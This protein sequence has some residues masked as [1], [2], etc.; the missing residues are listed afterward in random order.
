MKNLKLIYNPFSGDKSFKFDL[1]ICIRIFQSSGYNVSVFRTCE[2]G[3]IEKHIETMSDDYDV[4]VVS[5]GDGTVNIVLNALLKRSLSIPI[6]IIPSGTANDFAKFLGLSSDIEKNCK[7]IMESKPKKI[8]VGMVNEQ[9]FINVCGSGLLANV[10][11]HVDNDF[12]NT[13]GTLAYYI[14]AIEEIPKFSPMRLKIVNSM[15]I[16]EDNF[17]L[18]LVL[19][20]SGAGSFDKIAPSASITDGYFDFIGIKATPKYEIA[21]LFVKVLLGEHIED[22]NV[23]YFK[24]NWVCLENLSENTEDS[25]TTIDGESG[26]DMPVEIHL[27]HNGVSVFGNFKKDDNLY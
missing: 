11:Q 1:D 20:G 19:N 13:F 2:K 5:G 8:D 26:P 14:K 23:L 12:K 7:I 9:F 25:L 10:S 22:P 16:I 4:I 15:D 17:Y 6:G 21:K 27:I 24:D 18:V 3:D